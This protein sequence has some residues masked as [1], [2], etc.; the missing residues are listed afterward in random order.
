M[1]LFT[2]PQQQENQHIHIHRYQTAMKASDKDGSSSTIIMPPETNETMIKEERLKYIDNIATSISQ[3]PRIVLCL[4]TP[5]ARNAFLV[6]RDWN[7]MLDQNNY[8][9]RAFSRRVFHCED[10]SDLESH[11]PGWWRKRFF[12]HCTY[13]THCLTQDLKKTCP[14]NTNEQQVL[15]RQ[16]V[17]P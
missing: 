8:V 7:Q 10:P 13:I 1:H 5:S 9:W 16:L 6:C 12:E 14:Q 17:L 4:D 15:L 2:S 3:L 11:T